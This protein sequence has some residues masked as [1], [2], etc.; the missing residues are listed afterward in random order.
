MGVGA[1]RVVQ[2]QGQAIAFLKQAGVGSVRSEI[3]KPCSV[4]LDRIQFLY[5]F[6]LK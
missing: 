2:P 6:T 1:W 3:P 5:D 4:R